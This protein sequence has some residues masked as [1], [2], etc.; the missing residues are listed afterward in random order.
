MKKNKYTYEVLK[1]TGD[2]ALLKGVNIYGSITWEVWKIRYTKKDR[3]FPNG[4]VIPAGSEYGPSNEDWGRY[5]WTG[6]DEDHARA[7]Y[8]EKVQ[9]G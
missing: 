2:I 9:E 4:T 8:K 5:G 6:V 1:R 7:I 3:E